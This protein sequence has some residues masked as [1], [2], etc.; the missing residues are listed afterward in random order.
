MSEEH[1]MLV[2]AATV[3]VVS[4]IAKSTE[5]YRDALGFT[6]TFQYGTQ[7]GS[8]ASNECLDR[9][10]TSFGHGTASPVD[11]RLGSLADMAAL[12]GDVRFTQSDI[13]RRA[14]MSAKCQ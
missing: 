7:A 8:C 13:G 6:V 14:A 5:H 12:S 3:F 10:A 2:G 11:V 1:P 9:G 4:D